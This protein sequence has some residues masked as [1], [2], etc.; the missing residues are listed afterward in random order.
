[1]RQ[2][3]WPPVRPSEQ[4]TLTSSPRRKTKTTILLPLNGP[5][6]ETTTDKHSVNRELRQHQDTSGMT[7]SLWKA[8]VEDD[9]LA[10][11]YAK[12]IE[13]P[14]KYCFSYPRWEVSIQAM[15]KKRDLA[16]LN[17]LRIIEIF[18]LDLNAF[19]KLIMGRVYPK[20]E[21]ANNL[22]HPETYGAMKGKSAH[23]ALNS[24]QLALNRAGS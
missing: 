11:I 23:G 15:L 5:L 3:L 24:V 17:K 22:H 1:M 6:T 10:T 21:K 12:L 20:Y 2:G 9:V 18:E 7:M 19:L 4:H 14:F 13:L 16:Y 8:I